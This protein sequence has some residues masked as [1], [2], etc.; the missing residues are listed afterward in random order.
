[1]VANYAKLFGV[2]VKIAGSVAYTNG[3]LINIPRLDLDDPVAARLAYGYL[4][5]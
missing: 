1:M 4:A 2:K 3:K 5:H